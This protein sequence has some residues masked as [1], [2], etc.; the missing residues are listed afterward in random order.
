MCQCIVDRIACIAIAVTDGTMKGTIQWGCQRN[1]T[2]ADNPCQILLHFEGIQ[3][4]SW[5]MHAHTDDR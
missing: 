2:S 5:I 4:E 1:A 3:V